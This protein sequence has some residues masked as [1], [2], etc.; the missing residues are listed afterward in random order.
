MF[1]YLTITLLA[2]LGAL[3]P[4][5]LR[6][7]PWWAMFLLLVLFVGLRHHVGMDWNNYLIKA[8][9]IGMGDLSDAMNH[10]EP[11]YAAAMWLSTKAGFGVY[12][13]NVFGTLIFMA[14]LY[15]FAR[16]TPNPWLALTVAMPVLV[17]VVAMSANRQAVAIGVLL[18]LTASWYEYNVVKRAL[19]I[20]IA[21]LFHYS[22][23][24]F[25]IFLVT[26]SNLSPRNKAIGSLFGAAFLII[27]VQATDMISQ[28]DAMYLRGQSELTFSPG[29]KLHVLVNGIPAALAL[30]SGR[31]HRDFLL[32][33]ALMKQMAWLALALVPLSFLFSAASGRMT[34]YLF[35]VS[36][37]FFSCLPSISRPQNQQLLTAVTAFLF[38]SLAWF[39]LT[40]AN[41]SAAHRP[42]GNL[43]FL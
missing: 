7:G 8:A 4:S 6:K 13:V 16:T 22:A 1:P 23:S 21:T 19:L 11:L 41:S 26:D 27:L 9:I 28:Y 25:L 35:P 10:A 5:Q 42:Y 29:A 36:I 31:L 30:L 15:R 34:L 17:I 38:V 33:G 32:P 37:A 43:L 40:F 20:I 39:W 18:W 2:A 3:G 12:G 24:F 14:G